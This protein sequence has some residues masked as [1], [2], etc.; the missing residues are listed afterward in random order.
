MI[1]QL[2]VLLRV[3][4][5]KEEQAFRAVH[6]KRREV[7]EAAA[8][9]EL[10]R[11]KV[12]E[13]AATLPARE[14]AIYRGIIGRVVDYDEIEDAKNE[15]VEIE[16]EHARLVDTVERATHVHARLERELAGVVEA[17][18]KAARERDKYDVLT[19]EVGS[20]VRAQAAHRE[21]IEIEDIFS[22]RRRRSA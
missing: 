9:I 4:E 6:I 14:D 2:R 17:H 1:R 8:A 19:E 21:E 12:R 18:R 16:R 15:M 5:L 13:N 3:K 20:E 7:S 22:T 11:E 10:A